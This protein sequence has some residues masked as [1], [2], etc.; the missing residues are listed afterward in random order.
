MGHSYRISAGSLT[1]KPGSHQ[2]RQRITVLRRERARWSSACE[3]R[4]ID[5]LIAENLAGIAWDQ[6][7]SGR[8]AASIV[9]FA[10]AFL[11]SPSLRWV[12]GAAGSLLS[13]S[14]P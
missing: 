6:R 8:R 14:Q 1:L 13:V 12:R 2:A 4:Q 11:T 9:T 10:R 5:R 7:K 3:L